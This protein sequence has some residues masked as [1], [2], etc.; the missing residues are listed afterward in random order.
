M[1][2][3][4]ELVDRQRALVRVPRETQ[5]PGVAATGLAGV[6]VSLE[7]SELVSRRGTVPPTITP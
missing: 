3:I 2:D 1:P 5:L 6:G 7:L 4:H